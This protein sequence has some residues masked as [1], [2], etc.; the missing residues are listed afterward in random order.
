MQNREK[1]DVYS[2][3]TNQIVRHLEQGVRPSVRPWNAEH[4]AGRISRPLRHNG[5]PYSGINVLSLWAIAMAQ[6]FIAPIWMTFKQNRLHT[7]HLKTFSRGPNLIGS[8]PG[9]NAVHGRLSFSSP[10]TTSL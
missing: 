5:K 2:R 1:Q 9:T 7:V 8:Q 4:A 10:R 6:N 3:I